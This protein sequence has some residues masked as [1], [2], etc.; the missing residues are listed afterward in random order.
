MTPDRTTLD[1]MIPASTILN[2]T[3]PKNTTPSTIF[4]S[5]PNWVSTNVKMINLGSSPILVSTHFKM[6]TPNSAPIKVLTQINKSIHK[7]KEVSD[8]FQAKRDWVLIVL[9]RT[10]MKMI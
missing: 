3:N 8:L 1:R 6:M 5:I 9:K 2:R 4:Y 10:K 7:L